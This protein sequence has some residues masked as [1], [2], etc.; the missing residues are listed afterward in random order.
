[1]GIYDVI[2][3]NVV[4]EKSS[5][6]HSLGQYV[7]EVN[8][9]AT[10]ID[11]KN[12]FKAIYGVDANTVNMIISPKKTRL[13]GRGKLFTKR[14]VKKKAIVRTKNGVTIDINKIK[15]AKKK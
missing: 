4:T 14:R 6:N 5:E 7:F 8:K 1:M 10:K 9:D 2:I 15:E 13:I 12:A 3:R 11:V